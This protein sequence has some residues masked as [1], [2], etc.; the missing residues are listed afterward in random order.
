MFTNERR[1]AELLTFENNLVSVANNVFAVV[2]QSQ[3]R[4]RF[5]V[6]FVV[7]VVAKF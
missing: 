6:E 4:E 3:R 7:P 2:V 1:L 5:V